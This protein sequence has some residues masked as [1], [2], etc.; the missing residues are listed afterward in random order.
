MIEHIV[1]EEEVEQL[2]YN[3][4]LTSSSS[5]GKNKKKEKKGRKTRELDLKREEGT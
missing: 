3:P 1:E 2:Q 4:D 5:R